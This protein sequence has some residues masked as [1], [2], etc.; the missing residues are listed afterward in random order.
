MSRRLLMNDFRV[1]VEKVI[2][3]TLNNDSYNQICDL[4]ENYESRV[5]AEQCAAK[6]IVN[7]QIPLQFGN[8]SHIIPFFSD[9][10]LNESEAVTSSPSSPRATMV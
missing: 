9:V 7:K 3:Q 4:A 1:E 6:Y 2:L 8:F 10:S 5:L